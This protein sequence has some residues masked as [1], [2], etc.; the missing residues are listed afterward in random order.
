MKTRFRGFFLNVFYILMG[1]LFINS[2]L[3]LTLSGK[4]LSPIVYV[5]GDSIT[6]H[7]VI[8]DT[9]RPVQVLLDPG[10]FSQISISP[11]VDNEFDLFVHFPQDTFIAPGSYTFGMTV[12]ELLEG[13]G[14][15][16]GSLIS[17]SKNFAVDVYSYDKEVRVSFS[18]PNINVGN[19]VTFSLSVASMGY[20]P[21][22]AVQGKVTVYDAQRT[23]LGTVVT[24]KVPLRGLGSVTFAPV[25]VAE[26]LPPNSYS[27]KAVVTYDGREK[28]A[29]ATFLIGNMDIELLNYSSVL[30]SGYSKYEIVVRNK[31]G[32][33]LR[34]VFA[35]VY[36]ESKEILHTPSIELSPWMEGVLSGIVKTDSNP[37][38]YNGSIHVF[39][40]GEQAT[41]PIKVTVVAPPVSSPALQ[42]PTTE[43][44]PW[45]MG[46][47]LLV[48]L[49][50]IM[51]SVLVLFSRRSEV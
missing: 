10:P 15:G 1:L 41:F 32:D 34:N 50:L 44:P 19:N 28:S 4:Q 21:I 24:E 20:A 35:K 12:R 33:V 26:N 17:V 38:D 43:L 46:V 5:P 22:D 51:V 18:A 31:W 11:V 45:M 37:G 8:S 6:N 2:A 23:V 49:V 27:A 47:V 16:I 48:I 30:E 36:L 42:Q 9:E 29:N 14:N 13:D 7:Y 3:G 25:F 39:F 40:E